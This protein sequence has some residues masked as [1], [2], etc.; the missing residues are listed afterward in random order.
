MGEVNSMVPVIR[1]LLDQKQKVHLTVVTRTGMQQAMRLFESSIHVSYLPWDL[2]GLIARLVDHMRPRLLLL[3]ETEFWPGMLRACEKRGI[4]TIGINTRIS[5][6]SFPRYMATRLLWKWWLRPI[7]TF[8]AQSSIDAERL[9][10]IGIEKE[11]IE[12]VGNLKYA[13]KAPQA[14]ADAIRSMVDP[15]RSRPIIVAAS[16]HHD[17]EQQLLRMWQHWRQQRPGLLML[18][19]PRH[20]ERFDDVACD[21]ESA[22]IGFHRWSQL[23]HGETSDSADIVLVDAMGVLQQLYTIADIAIIG[24][25][26]VPVG[27]HNPLEA[28]IC[29]RGVVTGPNIEN[30]HEMMHDM[31]LSS[32]AIVASGTSD[33]EQIICRL[34]RHPDELRELHAH[35]TRFMNERTDV[36]ERV[37]SAIKPWLPKR[38]A[39]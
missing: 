7:H 5:D 33:L 3:T 28:A 30:F 29:G 34:L 13:I 36:L 27:G 37:C 23:Q 31:R 35:A 17:E 6:R 14:D 9:H 32:A 4:H 25:T 15:G 20:P 24:G 26:L 1:W 22:G 10:E 11:R 16:T 8:L 21:I 18:I 19:V 39:D 2:P 12:S 38:G